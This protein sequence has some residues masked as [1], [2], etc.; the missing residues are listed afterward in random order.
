MAPG[1]D[2]GLEP[3]TTFHEGAPWVGTPGSRDVAR[4]A[5]DARLDALLRELAAGFGPC[6]WWPAATPFEVL[7]GAV[8]T[9]N[10]AWR[11]V[12]LALEELRA[13]RALDP[14]VL[15]ELP[16]ARLAE[17]V[18][19]SGTF[20]VKAERLAALSSWYLEVGGLTA[21]RERPLEPLRA[22]LLEVRGIGPETA[23]SILCYAAGRRT[24]VVDAYAR[25]GLGRHGL[26]DA[27]LPYEDLR[28]FL[29]ERLV[30][31]G[32]V[33]EETHALFVRAGYDHCKPRAR[34]EACPVTTPEGAA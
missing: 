31:D 12:E 18:R 8:L 19:S 28:R 7:V 5:E 20:R 34:C 9:Q 24:A 3:V 29:M 22:A 26:V 1:R 6:H 17:L 25:R 32:V 23:D 14:T 33:Y 30:D 2:P 10:T 27:D 21:L 11:N 13:A 4:W 15:L 16:P